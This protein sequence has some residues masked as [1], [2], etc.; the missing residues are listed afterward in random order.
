[1]QKNTLHPLK[2][3]HGNG[4]SARRHRLLR[5][6][7]QT[8]V[9]PGEL[10]RLKRHAHAQAQRL[11]R[12]LEDWRR[13]CPIEDP[14]IESI[15]R[16]RTTWL[17]ENT[18]GAGWAFDDKHSLSRACRASI[19]PIWAE[20]L[21]RIARDTAPRVLLELGTNLGISSAYLAAGGRGLGPLSLP[22]MERR[23][24]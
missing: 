12:L 18:G 2:S 15:E 6:A 5:A 24:A 4:S 16:Q 20:L 19:P 14:L 3:G 13:R 8:L 1:M 22:S 10:S 21:Y 9:S 7:R 11:A 23:H 17:Q